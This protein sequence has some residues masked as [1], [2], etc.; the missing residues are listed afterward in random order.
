MAVAFLN[1]L[2]GPYTCL[3]LADVGF[4][5][6]EHT[7][8]TLSDTASYRVGIL[9]GKQRLMETQVGALLAMACIQLLKQ[10]LLAYADTHRRELKRY[11]KYSVPQQQVAVQAN[12]AIAVGRN[13]VVV[14]GSTAV[15]RSLNGLPMPIT[16][17]A[18]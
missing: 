7:Q 14:V 9:P 15:M 13:P 2:F 6:Q 5:E 8:T 4:L 10:R 18:P 1:L 3:N 17:T 16:N 11:F 12:V